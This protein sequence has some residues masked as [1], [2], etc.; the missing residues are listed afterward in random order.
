MKRKM[1]LI[2]LL[3]VIFG[4]SACLPPKL[5]RL[6]IVNKSDF[7]LEIQM[8]GTQSE[9]IYYLKV[10]EGS[11]ETPTEKVFTIVPDIYAFTPYYVEYWDPVYGRECSP[12]STVLDATHNSRVS[13]FHCN[14]K[15]RWPGEKNN[16]KYPANWFAKLRFRF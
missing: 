1:F 6:T 8:V 2:S 5:I 13:F 15:I 12:T 9:E 16:W 3:T 14:A 10:A 4:I 11:V 7:D